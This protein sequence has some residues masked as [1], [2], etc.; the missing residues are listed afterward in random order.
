MAIG[1]GS[2]GYL[3]WKGSSFNTSPSPSLRRGVDS[4]LI[5]RYVLLILEKGRD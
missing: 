1:R 3:N 5:G 2:R 4:T